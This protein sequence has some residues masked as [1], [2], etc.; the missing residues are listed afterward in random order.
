MAKKKKK[1]KIIKTA[2]LLTA[3]G[4]MV[5]V[6]TFKETT[7]FN[8]IFGKTL[9]DKNGYLALPNN[10]MF[11]WGE[12]YLDGTKNDIT[13]TLPRQFA[14]SIYS[15]QLSGYWSSDNNVTY[16]SHSHNNSSF[17]IHLNELKPITI[18][19]FVVGS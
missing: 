12:I 9:N 1:F 15:V 18:T 3:T 8:Q 11:Q 5:A 2:G 14:N 7:P 17:K 16:T 13:V 4:L 10:I 6:S 19:Y